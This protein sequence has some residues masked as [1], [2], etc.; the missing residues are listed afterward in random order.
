MASIL[1]VDDEKSIRNTV[2]AFL[3]REGHDVTT[4]ADAEQA[5]EAVDSGAFD[6]VVSDIVLPRVNGVTLLAELRKRDADLQVVMMT[7]EPTVETATE[8]LRSGAFDYLPKPVSNEALLKVVRNALR[9][10]E[11]ELDRKRLARENR[12]YQQNLERLVEERT[13][14]LAEKE[15]QLRQTQKMEELGTLSGG[16]A[17]DFNNL[18]TVIGGSAEFLQEEQQ[19]TETGQRDV[20]EIRDAARRASD[21]TRQL[22]AF[23]R[24]QTLAVEQLDLGGLVAGTGKMLRRLVGE[25]IEFSLI[26]EEAP[27]TVTVDPGQI[28]QAVM[29]LVVNA[30]DAMPD[31]GRLSVEL[32]HT[33]LSDEQVAMLTDTADLQSGAYVLISVCDTGTGMDAETQRQVFDPFFTTKAEGKGTGLGLST[34]YGIVRQHN[35]WIAVESTVDAGTIFRVYIPETVAA[36]ATDAAENLDA[37]PGGS[38]TILYVEDDAAVRRTTARIL[39]NLGYT[40]LTA[41]DAEAALDLVKERGAS[42]DLLVTDVIMPGMNGAQLADCVR[43][44]HRKVKVLY[45]TGYPADYLGRRGLADGVDVLNKPF[46]RDDLASKVREILDG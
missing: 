36:T 9:L 39:R 20:E 24:K 33:A 34:V 37:T 25:D 12:E 41:E 17:H 43:R 21:L 15:Q 5:L 45:A 29:N 22:L 18:L 44:L 30:R 4:A 26:A 14:A 19:L 10:R 8:A 40:V 6:V 7:G 31:G 2:K 23:S 16:V 28:E 42:I 27:Y 11:A 32:T 35:G 38:E 46:Q 3:V 1:V 13:Q